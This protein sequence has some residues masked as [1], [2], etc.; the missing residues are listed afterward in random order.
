MPEQ[1]GTAIAD[2]VPGGACRA[3]AAGDLE[4]LAAMPERS[5]RAADALR[6]GVAPVVIVSG[7]AVHS[8][9][10]EAL[11]LMYLFQCREHIEPER[12]LLEPCAEHTH[13]NLRN[14]GRWVD[15][16]G[17]RAAYLVTD[18]GLQSEYFQDSSLFELIMGSADQ[19]S[20]R[21]W[22][23]LLG[24]W[25]QASV[26]NN[27]GFWYTPYRFWAEPRE[28]LGSVTCVDEP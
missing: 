22:G 24:S 18:D 28:G 6:G 4:R 5:A 7:G 9:L 1:A 15:A 27:G 21:D 10:N 17:G 19:R 25:R 16:M 8:R 3:L 11:A 12:I 20:L 14:S 2:F 23:Y 13:T 26:G